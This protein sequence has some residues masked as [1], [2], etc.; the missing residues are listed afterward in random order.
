MKNDH[1]VRKNRIFNHNQ[2]TMSKVSIF[3][4]SLDNFN[5]THS[6]SRLSIFSHYSARSRSDSKFSSASKRKKIFENSKSS[7]IIR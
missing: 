6:R 1:K 5:Q 3:N 7:L 4:H 2:N